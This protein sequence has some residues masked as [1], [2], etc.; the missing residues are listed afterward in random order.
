MVQK[1]LGKKIKYIL[2][3][4]DINNNLFGKLLQEMSYI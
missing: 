1:L 2:G 3:T 4:T